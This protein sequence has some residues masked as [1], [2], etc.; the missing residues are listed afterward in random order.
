LLEVGPH[1]QVSCPFSPLKMQSLIVH[2]DIDEC[3]TGADNCDTNAACANTP[4]SFT[5]TCNLGFAGDGVTCDSTRE[6]YYHSS[7]YIPAKGAFTNIFSD[8]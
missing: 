1:A 8:S 5:C 7:F 2:P 4:G 3:A 6:Y